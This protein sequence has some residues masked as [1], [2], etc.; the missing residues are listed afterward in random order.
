[1]RARSGM[2]CDGDRC[3]A[4]KGKIGEATAC[5]IYDGAAGGLP[6][7]HAG[8]CRMR[9]GAEEVRA[10][11]LTLRWRVKTLR[12]SRLRAISSSS[13]S[14]SGAKIESGL[15]DSVIGLRPS[16]RR[17]TTVRLEGA[18]RDSA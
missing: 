16:D 13:S 5:A 3:A 7:L 12:P 15:V 1:M 17:T 8:R 18:S 14:S 9:D 4:L 10:A 2:R 6:H 11:G